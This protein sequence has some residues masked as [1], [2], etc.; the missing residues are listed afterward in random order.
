MRKNKGF[1]LLE[2]MITLLVSTVLFGALFSISAQFQIMAANLTTLLERD[3]N[4]WLAP[5]LLTRWIL[6]AGNHRWQQEWDGFSVQAGQLRVNTD[7]DGPGGF[8]DRKLK[9]SFETIALRC[10][11]LNLQLKS[12]SGT[13]QPVLKNIFAFDVDSQNTPLLTVNLSA[14]TDRPLSMTQDRL[15]DEQTVLFFLWN[16]RPNLFAEKP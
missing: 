7:I 2:L 3:E 1:P 8:P 11:R 5:L 15:S 13:F 10:R 14:K 12:G 4:F 16:Y 9:N 6:P